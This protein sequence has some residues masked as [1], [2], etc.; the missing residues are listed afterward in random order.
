[1][2]VCFIVPKTYFYLSLS[3]SDFYLLLAHQVGDEDREMFRDKYVILDNGAYELGEAIDAESLCRAVERIEPDEIV[4]PDKRFC[5][6]ETISLSSSFLKKYYNKKYTYMGVVQGTT[7]K[8]WWE[9]YCYFQMD[10]RV[11]VIGISDVPISPDKSSVRI[12]ELLARLYKKEEV[13][14]SRVQIVA[15]IVESYSNTKPLHI[16]G[17][18][19]PVE[20]RYL[21]MYSDV[22]RTDSKIAFWNGVHK[23]TLSLLGLR[24]GSKKF[25]DMSWNFCSKLSST[26][27]SIILYNISVFKRLAKGENNE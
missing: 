7:W 26:Q 23:D 14:F 17:S 18:I 27:M 1:M 8:D 24:R 20:L 12:S 10:A 22:I 21:S 13:A 15:Q 5:A 11:D 6:T 25:E 9:C 3:H 2:Q 4:L 16:L 19:D